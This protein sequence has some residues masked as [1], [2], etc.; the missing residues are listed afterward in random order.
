[1]ATITVIVSDDGGTESGGDNVNMIS[2]DVEVI[3]VNDEPLISNIINPPAILEGDGLQTI[4]IEGIAV[5]GNDFGQTL[6]VTALSDNT[7]LIPDP[8]VTYTSDDATGTL[9]YT[10]VANANG[11]ATITVT[12]SDDGGAENG[13]DDSIEIT[14]DVEVTAVNDEPLID[15]ISDPGAILEDA[16]EQTISLS[17]ISDNDAD[18]SQTLTVTAVSS[19]TDLIPNPTVTY[20]SDDAIGTLSYTPEA[21]MNGT[22]TITVTVSDDGGAENGGDDSV[23]I[24]FDVEVVAVNDEPLITPVSYTHLRAHET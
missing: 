15:V 2:F 10:P 5:G 3:A 16:S 12:V 21:N 9:S 14:F 24:T 7:A 23:E 19:D 11:T 18:L 4:N 1:M 13:G 22:A 6:T 20:S 17:G 8:T